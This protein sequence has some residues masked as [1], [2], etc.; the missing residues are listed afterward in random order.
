MV[1]SPGRGAG[2]NQAELH[3][4]FQGNQVQAEKPAD[5]LVE[6]TSGR[7]VEEDNSME[8][9]EAAGTE[10]DGLDAVEKKRHEGF[11]GSGNSADENRSASALIG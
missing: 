2:T 5:P 6:Q 4:A 10:A 8:K 3:K 11:V 9:V 7:P 1:G